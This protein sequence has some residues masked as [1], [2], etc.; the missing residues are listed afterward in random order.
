M[1]HIE[2]M[3]KLAGRPDPKGSAEAIMALET[4]LA[5]HHWDRVKSRDDTLT[6]NKKDLKALE[7]RPRLRLADLVQRRWERREFPR[8]SFVSPT[9][10]RRW[11]G[12]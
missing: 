3:F 12:L 9:I 8:S 6:Y 5:K 4:Q 2:A 11:P 1:A 10:S 7:A